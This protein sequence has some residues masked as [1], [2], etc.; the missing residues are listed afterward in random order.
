MDGLDLAGHER[1]LEI[2]GGT[3]AGAALVL[4]RL[5][6]GFLLCIDRSAGAVA[7]AAARHVGAVAAGRAAFEVSPLA[8]FEAV[9]P[10]DVAL[11][12]NVN[13]FWTG[14][15]ERECAA[16]AAALRPHGAVHLVFE[17]PG[18]LDD[19]LLERV[20]ANLGRHGFATTLLRSDSPALATVIGRL[21][22]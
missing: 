19:A 22:A 16:L 3:G 11:A 2:G 7:K 8:D 18:A 13:V 6:T 4:D 9:S 21:A 17:T 10:F 14:E 20:A 12:I 15:A 5:E 1:V